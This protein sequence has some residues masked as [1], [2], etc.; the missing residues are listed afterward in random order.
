M[1]G[2][3][4][5]G[6]PLHSCKRPPFVYTTKV[7]AIYPRW[8]LQGGKSTRNIS[9]TEISFAQDTYFGYLIIL[10]ICTEHGSLTAVLC[11]KFQNDFTADMCAMEE[12]Y[13][14]RFESEVGMGWISSVT[15]LPWGLQL[16]E[17]PSL[18]V[19]G[20]WLGVGV[21]SAAAKCPRCRVKISSV[22]LLSL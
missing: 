1:A 16:S 12:R 10:K 2:P 15:A 18:S 3:H 11:A 20:I 9:V 13:F 17:P 6:K 8:G 22:W 4:I 21:A 5:V 14:A 7:L 19:D